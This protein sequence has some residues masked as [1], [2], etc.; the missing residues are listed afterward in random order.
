MTR[1]RA[2]EQLPLALPFGTPASPAP[3]P[4]LARELQAP[5]EGVEFISDEDLDSIFGPRPEA[6]DVEGAKS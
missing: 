5:P 4:E 6:R 1:E 3:P 2:P